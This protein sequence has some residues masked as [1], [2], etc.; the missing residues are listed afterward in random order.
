MIGQDNKNYELCSVLYVYRHNVNRK[1]F[2]FFAG[3]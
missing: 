3:A 1:Y 2:T